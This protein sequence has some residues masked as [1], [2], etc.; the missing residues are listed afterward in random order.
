MK[1]GSLFTQRRSAS[2]SRALRYLAL[3][4]GVT[5]LL[6]G[7]VAHSTQEKRA[8]PIAKVDFNRDVRP[9][10]AANCFACHGQDASTRQANLRLDT[11]EAATALRNGGRAIEPGKPEKSALVARIDALNSPLQMPPPSSNHKLTPEQ[12]AML[13]RWVQQGAPY[14]IHWAFKP[15]MRPALPTVKNRTWVRNPIDAFVLAKLEAAGLKPAQEADR[16]TLIRRVS[17]DLTGLPPTP[18]EVDTFLADKSPNAYEKAVDRLLASPRY[19]EHWA[20][21]WLDLARYADTQGYEK[22]QPR[23]MWRYRDWVIDA[24]NADMP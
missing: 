18:P 1:F 14:D 5:P 10:L 24:F 17:L 19:G 23:T 7:M 6:A 4:F 16:L 11:R 13:T 9:I 21:M 20:R 22:D 8:P 3:W 12:R 15:V 2:F